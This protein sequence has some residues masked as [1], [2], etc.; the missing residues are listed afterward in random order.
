[1]FKLGR[2]CICVVAKWRHAGER[3]GMPTTGRAL[4]AIV[5]GLCGLD[6]L[7]LVV[8]LLLLAPMSGMAAE[9]SACAPSLSRRI[10]VQ[11]LFGLARGHG[12][13][14]TQKEWRAFVAHELTPRFPD[15][16]TML[17]AKG[18]WLDPKRRAIIREDSKLVEI[19]LPGDTYESDKVDAVIDVYKRRFNMQSVG[20]IVQT[21]CV[22][23]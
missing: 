21:A 5:D 18:Q 16:L 8:A 11:L 14:V 10:V 2:L 15:G 1:M 22:R 9:P 7:S 20:L 19:V 12:V 6:R 13:S 3:C 4:R 17:D 23:F